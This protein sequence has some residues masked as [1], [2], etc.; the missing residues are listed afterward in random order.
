M[1]IQYLDFMAFNI[2]EADL[3][4]HQSF[5]YNALLPV[6]STHIF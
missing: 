1:P 6:I 2:L 4:S 5:L 3:S